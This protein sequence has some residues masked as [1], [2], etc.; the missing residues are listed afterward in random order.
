[1]QLSYAYTLAANYNH[2]SIDSSRVRTRALAAMTKCVIQMRVAYYSTFQ[3]CLRHRI[4][5]AVALYVFAIL[6]LIQT[7]SYAVCVRVGAG[8]PIKKKLT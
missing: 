5:F 1:M 7:H 2:A 6:L 4:I 3:P 8:A